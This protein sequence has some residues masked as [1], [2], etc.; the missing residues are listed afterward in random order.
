MRLKVEVVK[1]ELQTDEWSWLLAEMIE[2]PLG[3]GPR[4]RAV[5]RKVIA[6]VQEQRAKEKAK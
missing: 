5:Y 4:L 6:Q 1:L 2:P 3:A